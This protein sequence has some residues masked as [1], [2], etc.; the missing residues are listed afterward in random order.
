M[1]RVLLAALRPFA[2]IAR[3]LAILRELYELELSSRTPPIYRVTEKPSKRDTE[4]SYSG[5]VD[6]TPKH[7]RWFGVDD[8]EEEEAEVEG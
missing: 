2:A 4:V 1:I 3:E 8:V 6:R 7:K 5:M